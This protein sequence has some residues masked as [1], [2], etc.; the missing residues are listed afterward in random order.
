[1][2]CIYILTHIVIWFTNLI[3]LVYDY[4]YDP[5]NLT[6]I[7]A[8]IAKLLLAQRKQQSLSLPATEEQNKSHFHEIGNKHEEK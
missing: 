5:G 4:D 8:A 3:K 1:M 6:P 7:P 2:M